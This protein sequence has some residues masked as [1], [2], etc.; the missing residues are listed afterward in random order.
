M[1]TLYFSRNSS[2][3]I[4]VAQARGVFCVALAQRGLEVREFS[5]RSIKQAV[6]G[7]GSAD[8]GQVQALVQIILGL[9][10]IP[11]PNHAADALGAAICCAQFS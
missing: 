11:S 5:P 7:L 9:D 1:E 2:S 4:P 10:Q 6:V 8:K 3:A